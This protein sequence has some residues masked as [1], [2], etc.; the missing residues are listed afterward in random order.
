MKR[1]GI[2][3][4]LL[5]APA[6]GLPLAGPASAETASSDARVA[7]DQLL[8]VDR[9]FAAAAATKDSV[10]AFSDMFHDDVV[11]P[12]PNGEFARGRAAAIEALRANP[13]NPA[14][15][16]DWSPIRAGISADGRHGYTQGYMRMVGED[17]SVRLAKYMTYWVRTADGWRAAAFKRFPRPEGEVALEVLPPSLPSAPAPAGSGAA[18]V[19]QHRQSLIAAEQAFSDEAQQVGIR[20]AFRRNGR[21]DAVNVGGE[22]NWAV[23]RDEILRFFGEDGGTSPVSWGADDALV[24]P[25]GDLGITFGVIRSNGPVPEGRPAASA[26]FTIWRRDSPSS[27]WRYVAE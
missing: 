14:S 15:R 24:A 18:E 3:L 12:L 2:W 13:F 5:A 16:S 9:A 21:P 27:P 11:M 8:D 4:S 1:F 26:F 17:G 6:L 25:S 19:A 23:G 10:T 22:A 20:E 7:V